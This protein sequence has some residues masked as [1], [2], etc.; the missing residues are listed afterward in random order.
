MEWQATPILP[1]IDIDRIYE[2]YSKN[3]NNLTFEEMERNIVGYPILYS[4]KAKLIKKAEGLYM[5][6]RPFESISI[7]GYSGKIYPLNRIR[8]VGDEVSENGFRYVN[9]AASVSFDQRYRKVK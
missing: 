2:I 5:E 9:R 8:V 1:F 3:Q 4:T 7:D 6:G